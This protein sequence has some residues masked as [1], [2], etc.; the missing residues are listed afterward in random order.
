[1]LDFPCRFVDFAAGWI[2]RVAVVEFVPAVIPVADF[3]F[4]AAGI[5]L[6]VV[7]FSLA[8]L[9]NGLAAV[10]KV[11][12]FVELWLPLPVEFVVF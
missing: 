2:F 5:G 3:V 12:D 9:E 10:A 11:P 7:G 1:M 4:A 8:A 6:A